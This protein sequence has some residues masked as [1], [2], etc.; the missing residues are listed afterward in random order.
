MSVVVVV[1]IESKAGRSSEALEIIK[2]SQELCIST[3]GCTNFEILQN[4]ND[5]NKFSFIERWDSTEIHKAFIAQLMSNE[6]FIKSM[7]VFTAGP[8]IEYFD[9][10]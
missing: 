8:H 5:E 7:E 10:V 9:Q 4:Q 6:N 3:D 1:N 2:G